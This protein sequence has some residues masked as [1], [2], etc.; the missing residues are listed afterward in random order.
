MRFIFVSL[1]K[2]KTKNHQNGGATVC[3]KKKNSL[4]KQTKGEKLRYYEPSTYKITS[5]PISHQQFDFVIVR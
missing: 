1:T 2:Q 5:I 4:V 3:M